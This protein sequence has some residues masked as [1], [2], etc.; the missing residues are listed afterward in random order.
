MFSI[1]WVVRTDLF[2]KKNNTKQSKLFTT[3]RPRIANH[4]SKFATHL[5]TKS[6]SQQ[7]THPINPG[8]A[9]HKKGENPSQSL[10]SQILHRAS[11]NIT[12]V[13]VVYDH[14]G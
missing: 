2:P 13:C 10:I 14:I 11:D 1:L 4:F 7:D 9:A 8:L 5:P 6:H 12:A 3:H